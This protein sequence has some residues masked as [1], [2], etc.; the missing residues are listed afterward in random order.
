[1]TAATALLGLGSGAT[2]L[3]IERASIAVRQGPKTLRGT[4]FELSYRPWAVNYTAHQRYATAINGSVPAPILRWKQGETVTLNIRNHL[5]E[6][7][8]IHWHGL[9]LP[10]GQDGVPGISQGYD[11]IKPG[12]SFQ[13]CFPVT[14]SGTYWYHSHSGF[15]EQTGAY[16][17]I[18]I[19]PK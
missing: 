9:I 7:A 11:G 17:V 13:H 6:D 15:Q 5:A 4:H 16:G 3:A 12:H 8:S 10:S 18:I 14:Q 1:M 2:A 19:E